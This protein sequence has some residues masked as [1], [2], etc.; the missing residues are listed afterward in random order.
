LK[1]TKNRLKLSSV[2][3]P[4]FTSDLMKTSSSFRSIHEWNLDDVFVVAASAVDQFLTKKEPG[5]DAFQQCVSEI[6][7][8]VYIRPNATSTMGLEDASDHY[9]RSEPIEELFRREKARLEQHRML[10]ERRMDALDEY[11]TIIIIPTQSNTLSQMSF[12]IR[13]GIKEENMGFPVDADCGKGG[14]RLFER[15]IG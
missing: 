13:K 15:G 2:Q 10:R 7:R 1:T 3:P 14:K 5:R 12:H 6:E 11:G 8:H 4:S 9:P